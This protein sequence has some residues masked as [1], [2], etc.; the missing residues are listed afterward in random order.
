M[1]SDVRSV[2]LGHLE[3]LSQCAQKLS[4]G[5]PS[6][7]QSAPKVSQGAHTI[8]RHIFYIQH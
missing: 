8:F 2:R 6:L 5:A 4:Q 1:I 3:T 7:S